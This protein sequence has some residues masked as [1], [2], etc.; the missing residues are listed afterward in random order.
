MP[1]TTLFLLTRGP[2][3]RTI[4]VL[5]GFKLLILSS[6]LLIK[7]PQTHL[8]TMAYRSLTSPSE[9]AVTNPVPLSLLL[10]LTFLSI[11]IV[12]N[13]ISLITCS[14]SFHLNSPHPS[15]NKFAT[16]FS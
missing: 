13:T 5:T 1:F 11:Q 12:S 9:P 16:V 2:E 3:V 10:L 14:L 8:Q 4:S 6:C 15:S 7:I